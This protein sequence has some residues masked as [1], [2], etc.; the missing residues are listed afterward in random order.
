VIGVLR[1]ARIAVAVAAAASCL[2]LA[3]AASGNAFQSDT[4]LG[5][6]RQVL[7]FPAGSGLQMSPVGLSGSPY[8]VVTTFRFA[9]ALAPPQDYA[10]ILDATNGTADTGLYDHLGFLDFYDITDYQ[11]GP[12]AVF[13][14]NTYV[15]VALVAYGGTD[16]YINGV[17]DN[18]YPALY[19][20]Q[21]N[22]LRFFKDDLDEDSAGA[23]S[24]IRV[25]DGAL[26]SAEVAAI[27]ADPRCGAPAPTPSTVVSPHKK[28]C[29]KHKKKHRSAESA[30]KKKCKK[31]RK[32]R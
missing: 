17:Q 15:T 28:K 24:C 18:S 27:G 23:V 31:K 19:A 16:G 3:Q 21:G 7:A 13:A 29:K 30:K 11:Q 8:S 20:V 1:G 14:D 12:S 22:T 5:V 10:R 6:Q 9:T 26:T 32:K 2:A 25:Y 4:V